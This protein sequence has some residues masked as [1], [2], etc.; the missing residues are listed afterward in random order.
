MGCPDLSKARF[1]DLSWDVAV[2]LLEL[3][4]RDLTNHRQRPTHH[5]AAAG[6]T[7]EPCGLAEALVLHESVRFGDHHGLRVG[8]VALALLELLRRDLLNHHQ[9]PT[10]HTAAAGST[11]EPRGL[12]EAL[13]AQIDVDDSGFC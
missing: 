6:L 3:L 8:P 1:E 2:A 12:A 9:R 10:H 4:R 7:E 11:E 13:A 5:T